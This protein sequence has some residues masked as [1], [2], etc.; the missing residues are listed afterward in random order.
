VVNIEVNFIFLGRDDGLVH[1]FYE[2]LVNFVEILDQEKRCVL[3]V[4]ELLAA[5][6]QFL[7]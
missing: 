7:N 5:N 3:V 4:F 2:E 1:L 6:H